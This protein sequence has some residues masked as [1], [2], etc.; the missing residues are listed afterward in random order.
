M[1]AVA[2]AIARM[3]PAF[4]AVLVSPLLGRGR[5]PVS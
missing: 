4:D 5:R 1:K 2:R 3:E